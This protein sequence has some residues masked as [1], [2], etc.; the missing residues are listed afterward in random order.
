MED[1]KDFSIYT[2]LPDIIEIYNNNIHSS[3]LFKPKEL[4]YTN[5]KNIINIVI[6][7]I[8][9]SRRKNKKEIEGFKINTKCLLCEN[10][11]INENILK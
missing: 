6:K 10:F 5:D 8:K 4:F 9:N 2:I 3:T 1:K 11:E 7:N